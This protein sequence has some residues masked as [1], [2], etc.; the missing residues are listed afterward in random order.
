MSDFVVGVEEDGLTLA[1][2]L[3]R[4]TPDLAWSRAR[5]LCTGGR[6]QLDGTAEVDP[7]AR[8]RAGQRVAV[9]ARST[10]PLPP[11]VPIVYEDPYVIVINKPAG[12][13]SVPFEPDETGT[14]LDL[15]RDA[16]R[17]LRRPRPTA[18]PLITVHR[19]DKETSG[20]IAF[21][22]SKPA[23]IGLAAQ[24]RDHTVRRL[25]LC[26]AHGDVPAPVRIESRL[27]ADRGDGRRGST[28]KP[29]VGKKAIT[30]VTPL[31]H[32]R[33]ATLCEVR[34]ETGKTHQIRIH[35]AER[36]HPLVGEKVYIRDYVYH[37]KEPIPCARL[38][39]HARTLGFT[40]PIT[41][42]AVDLAAEPPP[43]F[44]AAVARL[45]DPEANRT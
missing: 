39:L 2:V 15:V 21:A 36:G 30:H 20:L 4:R 18:T 9:T 31:E 40:H 33:G 25:Y 37:G 17:A 11:M 45:R 12:I 23:E 13:T 38:L 29:H 27:V 26:V 41:G 34:L 5:A 44:M 35:L 19:I 16:W 24:F 1:A 10:A 22:K 42:A 8:V 28:R 3:R 6:V 7:A 14:S 32:L 43:E